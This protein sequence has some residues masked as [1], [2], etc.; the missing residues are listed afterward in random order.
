MFKPKALALRMLLA[1]AACAA[2]SSFAP[3]SIAPAHS[4]EYT[5]SSANE[6]QAR[7]ASPKVA[8]G[9]TISL[10]AGIYRGVFKSTINGS[11]KARVVV[12]SVPGQWARIDGGVNLAGS[13]T[14]W[15][16]L[17]VFNSRPRSFDHGT[18]AKERDH[19]QNA[20]TLTGPYHSLVNLWIHD[21]PGQGVAAHDEESHD[22][23]IYGCL[24][25]NVGSSKFEHGIYENGFSLRPKR[26][27]NCVVWNC[28]ST[29]ITLHSAS[30]KSPVSGYLLQGNVLVNNGEV[31]KSGRNVDIGQTKVVSFT[32]VL[33]NLG[34]QA[35][36]GRSDAVFNYRNGGNNDVRDNIFTG[37]VF[38]GPQSGLTFSSTVTKPVP[39]V[40][41]N[42]NLFAPGRATI[43]VINPKRAAYVDVDTTGFVPADAVSPGGSYAL[44]D[45]FNP[46]SAP[47]ARLVV[48]PEARNRSPRI[49]VPLAGSPFSCFILLPVRGKG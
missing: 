29:G 37:V 32:S 44:F 48:T 47:V 19:Y 41:I 26:V 1:C 27:L 24:I 31:N 15:Q 11:A 38:A 4:A 30:G 20:F 5:V 45:A 6:L 2:P 39:T 46:A 21:I 18:D 22:A 3:A 8:P 36:P 28:A 25:W 49:R 23:L 33:D 35:R 43:T 16:D 14:Q 9:D 42:P 10:R 40:R 7:L 17:E 13:F 12:R 34:Y